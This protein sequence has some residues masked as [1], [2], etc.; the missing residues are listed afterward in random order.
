MYYQHHIQLRTIEKLSY[1]QA[2]MWY[3]IV[4]EFG[5]E[6][7][8]Y[9]YQR[10]GNDIAMEYGTY[11]GEDYPNAYVVPLVRDITS[12]EAA[13]IV[14]AWEHVFKQDFNIELTNQYS[15]MQTDYDTEYDIDEDVKSQVLED[16]KK[17][18]HNRWVDH[19]INEG[20]RWGQYYNSKLKTHP[21]LRDWDTLPESHR[22]APE[23]ETKDVIEFLTK[24][25]I[26]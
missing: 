20:W 23:F 16:M 6:N 26:I 2:V 10:N 11:E 12:D 9:S 21:S 22:R 18:N 25:K 13:F 8:V 3:Q 15:N 1:E 24:N 7:I 4:K 5:P 19:K 17:W 14:A